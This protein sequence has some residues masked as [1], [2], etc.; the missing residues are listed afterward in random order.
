M[1][2]PFW[3]LYADVNRGCMAIGLTILANKDNK[4]VGYAYGYNAL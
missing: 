4:T 1:Y 3:I 2:Y